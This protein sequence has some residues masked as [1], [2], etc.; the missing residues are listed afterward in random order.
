MLDE[1]DP[2]AR[3]KLL[4]V[5]VA[6][7]WVDGEIQAT[8]R[9]FFENLLKRL[10]LSVAER[11]KALGYLETPPHPAEIDPQ[12]IPHEQRQRLMELV[13]QLVNS[14]GKLGDEERSAVEQLEELLLG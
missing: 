1:L 6:A 13:W 10:P 4:K 8:E 2:S 14:D 11:D 12:K 5:L 7:A 3:M 9:R